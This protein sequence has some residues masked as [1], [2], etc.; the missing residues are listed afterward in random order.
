[1]RVADVLWYWDLYL[2]DDVDRTDWRATPSNASS[3]TA[4]APAF[5]LTAGEDPLRDDGEEY[6]ARLLRS[7]VTAR[8]KRYEGVFHGFFPFVGLISKATDANDDVIEALNVAFR[9][10]SEC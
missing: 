5:V 4:V 10:G 9:F 8:L 6:F 3:H 2:R 7:G 1:M